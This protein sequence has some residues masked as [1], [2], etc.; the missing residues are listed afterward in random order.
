MRYISAREHRINLAQAATLR[1]WLRGAQTEIKRLTLDGLRE[2][3]WH[4]RI[5]VLEEG[6]A[7]TRTSCVPGSIWG[8]DLSE[9]SSPH[10]A[11][12][13]REAH[14]AKVLERLTALEA[15]PKDLSDPYPK[16]GPNVRNQN[17]H[18]A[19]SKGLL[20]VDERLTAL[21][22]TVAKNKREAARL[23]P[24]WERREGQRRTTAAEPPRNRLRRIGARDRRKP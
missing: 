16:D 11:A 7:E 21:S 1:R 9:K 12:Q 5:R 19:L 8:H 22:E 17:A 10:D 24:R 13:F 2:V 4:E 20:Q 23:G 6:L 14:E 15:P 3:E 18:D